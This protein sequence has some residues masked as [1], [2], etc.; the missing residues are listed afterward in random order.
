[1]MKNTKKTLL[2]V[3][4]LALLI[5]LMLTGCGKNAEPAST[6]PVSQVQQS[7]AETTTPSETTTASEATESAAAT[8]ETTETSTETSTETTAAAEPVEVK[9]LALKGP[10]AIGLVD[11]MNRAEKGEVKEN[12]YH[13]EIAAAPDEALAAIVKGEVDIAAVPANM[14]AALYKKT[15]GAIQ[16]LGINTLGV[17]Y[18]CG[19]NEEIRTM[20][21]L[22][23]KII[24]ASGKG[25]TPEYVLTYLLQKNEVNAIVRWK[26]EHGECV[27]AL[28]QDPNAI[29]MLPQPF[30]SAAKI[31]NP[32]LNVLLDLTAEW[33]TV[34]PDSTLI[35]GVVVVRKEF[36][37][38]NPA[39][40]ANF[41]EHYA[42]SVDA[43]NENTEEIGALVE[44]FGIVPAKVAN[45]AIPQCNI[46][47]ITGE[48]MMTQ[49]GKYLEILHGMNP[50]AVG[51]QIPDDAFYYIRP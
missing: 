9:V 39:A 41:L 15:E 43:V 19:A 13:F 40:V 44:T 16:V 7:S 46:V 50:K 25:A 8:T 11:F 29:A 47:L 17:L 1:M 37:E 32:D 33:N 10:T 49:L 18:I 31:K 3:L 30:V 26:S 45:A 38:S 35:T 27:A 48:E 42:A 4:A 21:D 2:K 12:Q 28:A 5:A 14:A 36:A 34:T 24:Y 22:D 20:K 6:S 51:G 23:G